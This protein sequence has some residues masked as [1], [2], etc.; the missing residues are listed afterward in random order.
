MNHEPIQLFP[1]ADVEHEQK[2]QQK[3]DPGILKLCQQKALVGNL[4]FPGKVIA[5]EHDE[6]M[7]YA[8]PILVISDTGNNRVVIVDAQT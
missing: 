1:E 7:P 4:R 3:A 5:V 8:G 2:H 6:D